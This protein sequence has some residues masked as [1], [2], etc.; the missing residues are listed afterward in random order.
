MN[1][2]IPI[3]FFKNNH[4][5]GNIHKTQERISIKMLNVDTLSIKIMDLQKMIK[6]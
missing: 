6:K 2:I 1:R 4:T 5:Y 3:L